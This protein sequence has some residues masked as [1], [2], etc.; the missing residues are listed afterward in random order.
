MARKKQYNEDEVVEKAMNLFWENGYEATSMQMLEKEMGINKFSIYS[1]FG[2]KH[3]LFLESLKKYK[4]RSNNVLEKF[5]KGTNGIKDIKQFFY[6]SVS[7]NFKTDEIKGC[8]VTNTYNEFS[9][10]EDEC[11]QKQM[12]A[13]MDNL[14]SII[15]KKLKTDTSKDEETITK[16]ANYL[17]L[18]KNGLAAAARVNT[19]KEIEDYIEMVFK[20]L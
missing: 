5:G 4:S 3:G 7:S 11:I 16:Q 2:N 15:I 8:F 13:F 20:N 9:V 18:A 1:S 10:K 19:K 14:K 17:L 12:S 6:D